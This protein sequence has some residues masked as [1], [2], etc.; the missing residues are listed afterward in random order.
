VVDP[1]TGRSPL[2]VA[3]ASGKKDALRVLLAAGFPPAHQSKDKQSAYAL[4]QQL[5][6]QDL[7]LV[8]RQFLVQQVAANDVESVRQL[9][10]AGVDVGVADAATGGSLL[11]WAASCQAVEVLR[12]LLSR[13][14]VQQQKL[15]D[16]RNGEGATPLHLA[17]HANHVECTTLL[18]E[19]HA[20]ASLKGDKGFSKDRTALEL[21]TKPEVRDLFSKSV[22]DEG[23]KVKKEMEDTSEGDNEEERLCGATTANG[24]RRGSQTCPHEAQNGKLLLQLEEKDLLVSQ[25]KKTIEVLVQESQEVNMLGEERVMLDYV[26]KLR[27]EKAVVQRQLEDANDYIK[28]QQQQ[29]SSLKEQI[30]Q[31]AVAGKQV[32]QCCARECMLRVLTATSCC[33]AD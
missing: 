7:V 27:D 22:E 18:L 20:D 31:L 2:H 13:E 24:E 4:A 29:L 15:V 25:L 32:G 1:V 30:R 3:V 19:H 10:A 33:V 6:A 12:D 21:A 5:K 9:L 11:H 8:F 17:C 16:A 28:D 23:E 26:R 14:D